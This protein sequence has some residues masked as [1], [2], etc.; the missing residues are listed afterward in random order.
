MIG[1]IGRYEVLAELGRGGCGRVYR[2]LDPSLG[3][4]VAIK[5]LIAADDPGMLERFRIEAATSRR[6]RHANIVTIYD[7]GEHDDAPFLVMEL[8]EGED[9][10]KVV[11]RGTPLS[12]LDK[13]RIMSQVAAGLRHAHS[14]GII[15]RDVKPA[16]VMLLQDG[17]VKIMDFGIALITRSAQSRLTKEDRPVW[18]TTSYKAP[19]QFSPKVEAD[20]R[21]DI[22]AFGL[23]FYELL[24]SIHPFHATEEAF[25]MYNIVHVPAVPLGELRPE[26]P[27]ALSAVVARLLEKDPDERYQSFDDVHFDLEPI[28]ARLR[29]IRSDELV[30]GAQRLRGEGQLEKAQALVRDALELTPSAVGARELRET[31]RAELRRQAVRPRVEELVKRAH[32]ALAAGNPSEAVLRVDSA[33][34]LDPTNPELPKLRETAQAAVERLRAAMELLSAEAIQAAAECGTNEPQRAVL[35]L[36]ELPERLRYRPEVQEAIA[37]WQSAATARDKSLAIEEVEEQL[38]VGKPSRARDRYRRAVEQFGTDAAFQELERRMELTDRDVRNR[39]AF[40]LKHPGKFALAMLIALV[41][42]WIAQRP[43]GQPISQPSRPAPA[44]SNSVRSIEVKTDPAG[45]SVNLA[46]V[47]NPAISDRTCISPNCQFDL[48]PGTYSLIAKL[49]GYEPTQENVTL[50]AG[51]DPFVHSVRLKPLAARGAQLTGTLT[52]RTGTSGALVFIDGSRAGLTDSRGSFATSVVAKIHTVRV[53]KDGFD[54]PAP[55]RVTVAENS[56]VEVEFRLSPSLGKTIPTRI[57]VGGNVQSAR[58]LRQPKPS[59]PP[60]A[61]QAR[62]QGT[63]RFEAIIGK[64]GAVQQLRLVSGHPLLVPSA[65]EAVKQWV[66]QSTQLIGKPVEVA[67]TIDVNFTLSAPDTKPN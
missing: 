16:N 49:N 64:D 35:L 1:R 26:F 21:S 60:L 53:F 63:V 33:I 4:P 9:L 24:T 45:A 48:P 30:D 54:A 11:Q 51:N 10:R 29:Q 15:H 66:Y 61:K 62:I 44:E 12:L 57:R 32:A 39:L 52:V 19:E 67:T 46:P 59:Y 22:F 42:A 7:F 14:H 56:S 8:L 27:P 28:L 47:E 65:G 38:A 55:Q 23:V 2:C 18:G 20:A 58:I 25:V 36:S 3:T 37:E 31:L 5:T 17:S 6:L 13:I 34:G 41:A 43:S 50:H 40:L